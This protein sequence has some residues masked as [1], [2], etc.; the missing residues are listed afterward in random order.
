MHRREISEMPNAELVSLFAA[1]VDA[2]YSQRDEGCISDSD[3]DTFIES[4]NE[5]EKRGPTELLSLASLLKDDRLSVRLEA[6]RAL[7]DLKREESMAIF[8]E[9]SKVGGTIAFSA[10][11]SIDAINGVSRFDGPPP[12]TP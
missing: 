9:L 1:S 10:K 3:Y 4:R 8:E 2:Y 12:L 5:L 11:N 7:R 6:A